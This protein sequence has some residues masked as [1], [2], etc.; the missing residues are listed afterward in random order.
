[1]S[2]VALPSQ[3]G[4]AQAAALVAQLAQQLRDS[5]QAAATPKL[6]R[7]D[8]HTLQDFDSSAL[9]LVLTLQRLA[10]Q[11]GAQLELGQVPGPLLNLARLYG[12]DGI[13]GASQGH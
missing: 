2:T 8:A 7:L 10:Q 6:W 12:V 3:I 11:E 5:A 9:S 1:M 4:L 13:L